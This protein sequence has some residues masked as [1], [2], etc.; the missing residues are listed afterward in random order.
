MTEAERSERWSNT[1]DFMFGVDDMLMGMAISGIGSGI[2]SA[3]NWGSTQSTNEANAQQA[4][5]N[6]EFQERMS[7]TA[8]Q[9]GMADMKAAGLNPILAYQKGGASSPSG[10]QSTFTAP[11]IQGNPVGEAVNTGLA[12][13]KN[14]A[15]VQHTE[16][17]ARLLR[18]QTVTEGTRNSQLAADIA[19]RESRVAVAAPE[20]ER[21]KLDAE[22]LRNSAVATA[23]K[24]GTIAEEGARIVNPVAET[25]GRLANSAMK[26]RSFKPQRSTTETTSTPAPGGGTSTFS[27]RFNY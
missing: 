4:E 25:V 26:V 3:F 15:D 16:D 10:S 17:A 9:R 23:R 2:T 5:L 8:Y 22:V 1:E 20:R 18:Q 12:L 11:Q 13:R 7:S 21:A 24:A 27:E 6:R 19:E 14:V